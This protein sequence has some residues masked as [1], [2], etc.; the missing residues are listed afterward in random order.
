MSKHPLN[1]AFRFLLELSAVIVFGIW[2]YSLAEGGFRIVLTILFPLLFAFL[3]G[4][5]AVR[6]DP[7]RSGKTVV[8]TPGAIRLILEWALFASAA[9]MLFRL[10]HSVPGWIFTG[11]VLAHYLSSWDRIAWLLKQK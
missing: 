4:V 2:G 9:W 10:G 3:W 8:Q 6:D 7:S 5:F 11:L 1:L